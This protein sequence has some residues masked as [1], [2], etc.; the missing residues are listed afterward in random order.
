MYLTVDTGDGSKKGQGQKMENRSNAEMIMVAYLLGW[1]SDWSRMKR[2]LDKRYKRLQD[3][4]A[5]T[6][7]QEYFKYLDRGHSAPVARK[8][9][10][11]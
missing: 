4:K 6:K 3:R 8:L 11:F 1:S 7:R 5:E 9:A 2:A 10:S